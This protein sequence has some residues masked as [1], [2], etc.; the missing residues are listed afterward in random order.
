[1][2]VDVRYRL[3]S[4]DGKPVPMVPSPNVGLRFAAPPSVIVMHYTGGNSADNAI[5]WLC[6]RKA[7]ASAHLVIE[8][9][10]GHITQLVPFDQVAHHAGPSSW[11]GRDRVNDWSIGI[12]LDNPGPLRRSPLGWVTRLGKRVADEHVVVHEQG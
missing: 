11:A 3:C 6:N 9:G 7:K 10:T 8:R 12:E 1:M 2:L 5:A 4:D